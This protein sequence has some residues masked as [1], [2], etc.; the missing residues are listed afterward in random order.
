[1]V[2]YRQN[3]RDKVLQVMEVGMDTSTNYT[4][5]CPH[6]VPFNFSLNYN[7]ED[8]SRRSINVFDR[9]NL[10]LPR[11]RQSQSSKSRNRQ[12]RPLQFER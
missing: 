1:M 12:Q 11:N 6:E 10:G 5:N 4:I 9:L 2:E 8:M 7:S 3:T